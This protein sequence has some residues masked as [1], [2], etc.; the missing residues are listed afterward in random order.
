M[1]H[2]HLPTLPTTRKWRAVVDLLGEGATTEAVLAAS[3]EAAESQLR[4]AVNDPVYVEAVRLL[5]QIPAAARKADFGRALRDLGIPVGDAPDLS[6][7]LFAVGDRLD[8]IARENRAGDFGELARRA[9]IASLS[10]RIGAELPGL[11]EATPEDV[12]TAARRYSTP[13]DFSGLARSFYT[14]LLSETLSSFLD[15]TLATHVGPDGRFAHAG[16]RSAFD[17]ALAQHC[18]ETTRILHE[19]SSGW[20]ARHQV[21]G[22][23]ASSDDAATFGAV[24]LKK[25]VSELRR[26][27]DPDG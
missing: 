7:V 2:N 14:R 8:R 10:A 25:L 1:G 23:G 26:R 11:F 21:R 24:A 16:A 22:D 9:L 18:L 19:F 20:H 17:G 6:D 3:A 4:N 5:I 13:R 15:R 12:V 27:R